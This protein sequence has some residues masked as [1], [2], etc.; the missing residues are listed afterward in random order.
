MAIDRAAILNEVFRPNALRRTVQSYLAGIY[1]R[2]VP[3][4]EPA[5]VIR[6]G[7][8]AGAPNPDGLAE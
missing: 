5:H 1:G 2:P 3:A 8:C 6:Y 7:G 4:Y